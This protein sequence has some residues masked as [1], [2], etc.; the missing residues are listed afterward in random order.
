MLTALTFAADPPPP[1]TKDVP[2]FS[3]HTHAQLPFFKAKD[4]DH[5]PCAECHAL[6]AKTGEPLPP[7]KKGHQPCADVRCHGPRMDKLKLPDYA[8]QPLCKECHEKTDKWDVSA[9]RFLK[10]E[11]SQ[12]EFGWR[13]NHKRHLSVE[14]L[15]DC[16]TCHKMTKVVSGDEVTVEVHRPAHAECIKCH[17]KSGSRPSLHECSSCH[18][19]GEVPKPKVSAAG[20]W[21]V[22][23][24]FTHDTHRLDVRTAK[25]KPGG[26]GRGWSLY[27]KSTAQ[28]L[29]C[30]ACHTTAAK[31]ET[32]KD[33]DLLGPCAM[34]KT[35]MGQCHN[36]RW[37]FQGSGT[38][39]RDCLLCHSNVD[40]KTPAPASHCG[41][42]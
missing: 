36:G 17:G 28:T 38:S 40:E 7:G 16:E 2:H 26:M 6:E 33:M 42:S 14:G 24:K 22:Y 13:I 12:I 30:G 34:G 23:D 35:C 37:A 15:R 41:G 10:R 9:P 39:I 20:A 31:S 27:D 5:L 18:Q 8:T 25:H 4:A 11:E 29:S 21:R 3:H 19:I 1:S 32:I